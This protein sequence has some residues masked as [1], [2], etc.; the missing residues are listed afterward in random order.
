[1]VSTLVC[2]FGISTPVFSKW[3]FLKERRKQ[4][5]RTHL[6]IEG[7]TTRLEISTSP[8]LDL[9]SQESL[10]PRTW[11]RHRGRTCCAKVASRGVI[12]SLST[13]HGRYFFQ[14]AIR[15]CIW[16]L[17]IFDNEDNYPVLKPCLEELKSWS[18][19]EKSVG[20]IFQP[21]FNIPV[22]SPLSRE[23][24]NTRSHN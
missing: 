3:K 19:I 5:G 16:T 1:M 4:V 23:N 9:F 20:V 15:I 21:F 13:Y 6:F 14:K 12:R 24:R 18:N 7:I 17:E 11:A 22:T 8:K 2:S 10:E